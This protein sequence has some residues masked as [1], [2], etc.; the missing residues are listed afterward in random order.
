MAGEWERSYE[1]RLGK[2]EAMQGGL[3][4]DFAKHEK[5]FDKFAGDFWDEIAK[6]RERMWEMAKQNLILETH[7]KALQKKDDDREQEASRR[8]VGTWLIFIGAFFNGLLA[9]VNLLMRIRP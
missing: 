8:R 4:R 5:K 2:I 9:V 7:V 6:F 3:I 1:G